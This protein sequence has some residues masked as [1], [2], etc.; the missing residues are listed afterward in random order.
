MKRFAFLLLIVPLLAAP[1]VGQAPD[2]KPLAFSSPLLP[3]KVGNRWTYQGVDPK[4]KVVM[5]VDRMEPIRRRTPNGTLES[6]ESYIVRITSG[7]KALQEQYYVAEDGIY[8][9]AAAGKEI[10][11]PL[12]IMSVKPA[13]NESWACDSVSENTP[14][15]GQFVVSSQNV[16]L[17]GLGPQQAWVSKTKDFT[18]G[19]QAMDATYWFVPNLGIVQ[20]HVK[21]GKFEL[22]ITL[23]N[24]KGAAAGVAPPAIAPLDLPPVK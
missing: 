19:D 22:K 1:L 2:K 3:L 15:K 16:V 13:L 8:R 20:Q 4:E 23:E 6:L 9:Y 10:V 7:D 18:V 21:A 11:P 17:P 12:K 5:T 24:F 14:I